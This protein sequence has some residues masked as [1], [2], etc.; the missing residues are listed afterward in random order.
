MKKND[1]VWQLFFILILDIYHF[2]FFI[3]FNYFSIII[4]SLVQIHCKD[5]VLEDVDVSKALIEYVSQLAIEHLVIGSSN[6][7]GFLRYGSLCLKSNGCA[8]TFF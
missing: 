6:K 3:I 5:V 7:T 1:T 2:S 8:L 4:F